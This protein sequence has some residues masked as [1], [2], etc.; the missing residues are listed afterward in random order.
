VGGHHEIFVLFVFP[1]QETLLGLGTFATI[2]GTSRWGFIR[3]GRELHFPF[4]TFRKV[5]NSLIHHLEG[6]V[7]AANLLV[8]GLD[9]TLLT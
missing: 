7:D 9:L 6:G 2:S 5:N 8:E 1:F 4:G 3:R